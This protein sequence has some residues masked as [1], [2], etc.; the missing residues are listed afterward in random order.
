MFMFC[1]IFEGARRHLECSRGY[2]EWARGGARGVFV[3]LEGSR[4]LSRGPRR[5]PKVTNS[6]EVPA[7]A[8]GP[9]RAVRWGCGAWQWLERRWFISDRIVCPKRLGVHRVLV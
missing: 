8:R 9:G 5:R 7:S 2:L 1:V 6:S 4:R 3:D